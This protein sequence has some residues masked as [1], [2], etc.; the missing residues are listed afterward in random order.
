LV[1]FVHYTDASQVVAGILVTI[2]GYYTPFCIIST[3]LMSIGA[4]LLTTL[5]VTTGMPKWIGYQLLFGAGVGFGMQQSIIAVQAV[6]ELKDVATGTAVVREIA[7]LLP[8]TELI[9]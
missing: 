6:L 3:V 7:T 4:G 5:E 9:R 1:H 8:F 2:L